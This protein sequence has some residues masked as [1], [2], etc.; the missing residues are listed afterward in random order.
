MEVYSMT[1]NSYLYTYFLEKSPEDKTQSDKKDKTTE[2]KQILSKP[3][4]EDKKHE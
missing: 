3:D 1:D 4:T 2:A